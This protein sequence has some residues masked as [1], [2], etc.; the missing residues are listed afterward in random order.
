MVLVITA[1]STG[2]SI[3]RHFCGGHEKSKAIILEAD[4]CVN[5][6]KPICIKHTSTSISKKSCCQDQSTYYKQH[7]QVDL[8]FDVTNFDDDISIDGLLVNDD[9]VF[10][11]TSS[12]NPI[13]IYRPPPLKEPLFIL[14]QSFLL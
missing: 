5:E 3:N 13:P 1:S 11:T 7:F 8:Q 14:H 9:I 12:S 10:N 6:A 2:F 4:R